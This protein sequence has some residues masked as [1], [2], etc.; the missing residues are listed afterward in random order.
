M[1]RY[2][3]N[4]ILRGASQCVEP[5]DVVLRYSHQRVVYSGGKTKIKVSDRQSDLT[6]AFPQ[7]P[8]RTDG[9]RRL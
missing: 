8:P 5:G 4:I 6:D 2:R 9:L 7:W 1:N 3:G